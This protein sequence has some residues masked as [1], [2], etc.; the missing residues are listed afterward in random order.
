[1]DLYHQA[2]A[3]WIPELPDLPTVQWYQICPVNTQHWKGWP[4]DQN[5]YTTPASW[6]RGAATL[7]IG[8]LEPA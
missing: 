1:M 2:M 8:A 5:P 7:F 3:V 6:H 4:N